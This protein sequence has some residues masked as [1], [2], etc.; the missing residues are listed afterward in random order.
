MG[1]LH[2]EREDGLNK[3]KESIFHYLEFQGFAILLVESTVFKLVMT[4]SCYS[5]GTYD[6]KKKQ[7]RALL[8]TRHLLTTLVEMTDFRGIKEKN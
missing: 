2:S 7:T 3:K 8:E 5:Y 4:Q 1:P 6:S